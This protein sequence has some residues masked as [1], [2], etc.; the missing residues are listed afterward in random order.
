MKRSGML[1]GN[2]CFDPKEVLKRAWFKLASYGIG[3]TRFVIKA[4]FC[5]ENS[6]YWH[7]SP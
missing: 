4:S 1:V 3:N 5:H 7:W 6:L 2:F